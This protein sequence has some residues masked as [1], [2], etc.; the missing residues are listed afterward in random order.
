MAA[1]RTATRASTASARTANTTTSASVDEVPAESSNDQPAG[2]KTS[3]RPKKAAAGTKPAR[4]PRKTAAKTAK[5][6][7]KKAEVT[8][9]QKVGP[10]TDAEPE[11]PVDAEEPDLESPDLE[12]LIWPDLIIAG[13]G[14]S[15]RADKWLPLLDVRTRVVAAE[16]RND[17][18]IVGAAVAAALGPD[19]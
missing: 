12:D 7:T 14:V 13:G 16:L 10:G 19:H 18:G 5:T 15:K 9:P 17:A 8:E 2:S 11:V 6:G 1:A 3:T 4:A